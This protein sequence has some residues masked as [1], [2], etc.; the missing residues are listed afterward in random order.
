MI[1][2]IG[3][4]RQSGHKIWALLFVLLALF[5]VIFFAARGRFQASASTSTVGTVLAPFEM[6]FSWCGQQIRS[7]TANL[8]EIATVHEQNKMLKNEID[9]LR[10]ENTT[11][12]EYAAENARLRELLA[13]KQAAHQFD[14]LAARVIGRDAALWTSTIV[15]D[16]GARD[17][18]RE[19][20]P[21][22]TGKGLVG[23]VT[24]VGPISS[25]VQ[26]LLDVRSSV[27]TLIQR[28]ESRVTGIVTGTMDNPYMPQMINIP[29]NADVED[30]DAVVTSGFGGVYPKGIMVGRVASQRSDDSGL[31]K[32]AVIETAVDFQRLDDVAIIRA[33]R[34][35]PPDPVQA[36]PLS[37]GAAA[38]AQVSAAQ[39]KAAGQ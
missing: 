8:W 26:L 33:S 4:A 27:G 39:E 2:R 29:R 17:G 10:R 14:L 24:E 18:V 38:A 31:L 1:D 11:A 36:M 3:R 28:S 12:E 15:I 7:V 21:V 30:G 23:H 34:A 37:P 19:N 5:C 13:Y 25:K 16:R 9:Q 22:V 35:A 20:M 32:I 6:A